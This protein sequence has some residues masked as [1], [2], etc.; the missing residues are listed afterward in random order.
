M[1]VSDFDFQLPEELIAQKPPEER[2]ASRMLVVDRRSGAWQDRWFRELPEFLRPGD[3]L[4][5]N[6]SRVV[7]A[8]LLGRR[9]LVD[10]SL[11]AGEVEALLVE[12]HENGE[13]TALVRPGK[14]LREG[15]RMV[16]GENA[17]LE[18][19]VISCG[20]FGERRI[21][22][23]PHEDFWERLER[24]GHVPLPPYI[25]REDSPVDRE[26]Y[27]T[28]VARERGS[29]AAPTAGLHFTAE[30]LARV[31]AAGVQVETITLH[32]GLGTF[33]PVRVE[34]LEKH[35][36]HAERYSLSESAAA[37]LRLAQSE[38]R[39]VIA[40]GT[41]VAR[42]LEH[43]ARM[44]RGLEPHRGRTDIFLYPGCDG[45][46][47]SEFRLVQ[48]LLTNFH[49]PESTLLMLV[50]AFAGRERVLAAYAHAVKERYR[51]FSYG[52]CMFLS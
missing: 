6:D 23:L 28:V 9:V 11:G 49:L 42:T 35:R 41:T 33:Q 4:V 17:A 48:G 25:R 16:F 32:V 27:Q 13:W 44:P 22:F 14:L 50:S 38:G 19:E 15:Q 20:E 37:A 26:R 51:F 39:R 29:V 36:M 8:R 43:C 46:A 7:P 10:G 2:G 34:K 31:R 45:D 18:A 52:D 24:W 12:Q 40:V 5:M 30:M 1:N 21:R 3:L 47:G